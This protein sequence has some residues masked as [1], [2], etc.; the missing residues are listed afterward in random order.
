MSAYLTVTAPPER[1]ETFRRIFGTDTVPVIPTAEPY[2]L[3][4]P[5]GAEP[6]YLLDVERIPLEQRARLVAHLADTFGDPAELIV[7]DLIRRGLPIVAA[8]TAYTQLGVGE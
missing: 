4:L 5:I 3:R 1:V 2:V 8:G 7:R 6:C